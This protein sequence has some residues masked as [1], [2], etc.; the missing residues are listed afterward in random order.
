M[1]LVEG[2]EGKPHMK[3]RYTLKEKIDSKTLNLNLRWKEVANFVQYSKKN[4]RW[5]KV[6][7]G[8]KRNFLYKNIDFFLSVSA[9][10]KFYE[11]SGTRL[12]DLCKSRECNT[13]VFYLLWII[14]IAFLYKLGQ[15]NC[16]KIVLKIV[17]IFM[18]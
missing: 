5:T 14:C 6:I 17:C 18:D 16:C 11:D 9:Q 1:D 7:D 10:K 3:K 8:L 12:D 13:Y 4:E 15:A 2:D